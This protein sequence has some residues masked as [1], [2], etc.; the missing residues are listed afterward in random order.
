MILWP[1]HFTVDDTATIGRVREKKL[2]PEASETIEIGLDPG[3]LSFAPLQ[4]SSFP[5]S[6]KHRESLVICGPWA[7]EMGEVP[8]DVALGLQASCVGQ[9]LLGEPTEFGKIVLNIAP[10]LA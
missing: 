6:R 5:A 9:A 4:S 2:R 8:K 7:S 10:S 3:W 1:A